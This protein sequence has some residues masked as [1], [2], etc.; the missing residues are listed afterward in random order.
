MCA[1]MANA[2]LSGALCLVFI[3]SAL[4]VITF[5]MDAFAQG[6]FVGNC[7]YKHSCCNK[8]KNTAGSSKGIGILLFLS[9]AQI[10]N[11]GDVFI[12]TM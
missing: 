1:E 10:T 9:N 12:N 11:E 6:E 7:R 2:G 4:S 8:T 3:I 5:L